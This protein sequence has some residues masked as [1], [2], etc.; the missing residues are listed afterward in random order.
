M[1]LTLL[2][3][4]LI[5]PEPDE[6][7]TLDGLLCPALNTLIAR[8]RLTRR[9]PQSLEATLT[10]AFGLPE[11]APYAAFRLL[12]EPTLPSGVADDACWLCADPV[13]LR[14]H[15]ERLILADSASFG[16]E[17][18]EAQAICDVLNR[19]FPEVGSFH[20]AAAERWYLQLPSVRASDFG[21]A[22]DFDVPPLSAI[23]GRFVDRQLPTGA[24]TRWL[25]QLLNEAQMLLHGHP[26]NATREEAGRMPINSLWLWGAGCLPARTASDFDGVWSTHPL[27]VGLGRAAGVPAHAV[28]LDAAALFAHTAPDSHHLVLLE[29]LLGAVQYQ[30]GDAYRSALHALDT[31]WFAPVRQ[32][33]TSGKLKRLRLESPTA[34]GALAWESTPSEQ[35]KLWRR[36]QSLATVAQTLA[37]ATA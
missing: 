6:R 21:T 9:A 22:G 12:G 8:S 19:Q 15:Q 4:E 16:I 36:A 10:D 23:V 20:V 34:Y 29:D 35:W 2:I 5:W 28:P 18:A 25:R 24:Q 13:H 7:E 33:L 17:L 3:P 14:F 26:A 37:K 1:Q 31:R 11:G 27:A 30:N 32:A